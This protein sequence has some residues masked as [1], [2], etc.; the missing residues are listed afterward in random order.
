MADARTRREPTSIATARTSTPIAGR[1]RPGDLGID[2][3]AYQSAQDVLHAAWAAVGRGQGRSVLS[4]RLAAFAPLPLLV[5]DAKGFRLIEDRA[6]LPAGA[7]PFGRMCAFHGQMGMFV[8]ALAYMLSH[9]RDGVRQASEDA[10]LS[11]NYILASLKDV[12]SA[13][14]WR[15]D[16]AC[17]KHCSTTASWKAPASRRLD[18]A[19]AMIDEGYHPIDDVFPACRP[20]RHADR[21]RPSRKSKESL[22]ASSASCANWRWRPRRRRWNASTARRIWLPAVAS[23]KTAAARKPVLRLEAQ[24]VAAGRGVGKSSPV[25]GSSS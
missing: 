4:E 7:K 2:A 21:V 8:R 13:P 14:V 15:L 25:L 22:D 6:E 9:G 12:M 3:I 18:F 17:M 10:V 16:R 24:G 20:R 5:H 11:A 23:M 19:K 1:V